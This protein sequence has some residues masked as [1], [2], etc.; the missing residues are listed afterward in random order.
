MK[1]LSE[2]QLQNITGGVAEVAVK[3]G[4]QCAPQSEY[5]IHCLQKMGFSSEKNEATC[6]QNCLNEKFSKKQ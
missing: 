1:D 2:E 3:G 5:V 6:I 4:G